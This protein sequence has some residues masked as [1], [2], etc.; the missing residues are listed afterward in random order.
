MQDFIW[1]FIFSEADQKTQVANQR[2]RSYDKA[3]ILEMLD[4]QTKN[5]LNNSEWARHFALSRNTVA[6]WKNNF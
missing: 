1:L 4:Y 3:S 5:Q 2:Y 6:K